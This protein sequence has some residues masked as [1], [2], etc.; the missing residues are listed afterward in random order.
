M[1]SIVVFCC[2]MHV[3]S[4]CPSPLLSTSCA[5]HLFLTTANP[6][7][8]VY[9]NENGVPQYKIHTP[10]MSRDLTTVIS[11]VVDGIPRRSGKGDGHDAEGGERFASLAHIDW[12]LVDSSVIRFRG[13]EIVSRDFFRKEGVGW[14]GPHRVFTALDGKEYKWIVGA[15]TTELKTHDDAETPVACYHPKKLGLLSEPQK[16]WFE[17]FQP[18]EAMVDEIIVTF[19]Y[20]ERLLEGSGVG[21]FTNPF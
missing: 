10:L 5:M 13:R 8:A 3:L 18:Y 14:F 12:H 6:T 9:T 20:M 21:R 11:R 1:T 7:N 17:I 15:Q 2:A 16:A 19:V 4:S